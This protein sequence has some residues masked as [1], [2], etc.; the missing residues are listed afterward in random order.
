MYRI[1]PSSREDSSMDM[2]LLTVCLAH[3]K[4]LNGRIYN[5]R[6]HA[7]ASFGYLPQGA[8][9][10]NPV[11]RVPTRPYVLCCQHRIS[12]SSGEQASGC[13]LGVMLDVF[14]LYGFN[15]QY[16]KLVVCTASYDFKEALTSFPQCAHCP[17]QNSFLLRHLP[18]C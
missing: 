9:R 11:S 12:Q 15:L 2:K 14:K 13:W 4:S 7:P 17:H 1:Q 5:S 16:T 10:K 6:T 18:P 3:N 8:Q